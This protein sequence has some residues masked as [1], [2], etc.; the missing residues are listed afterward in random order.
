M[1][2][3]ERSSLLCKKTLSYQKSALLDDGDDDAEPFW[4]VTAAEAI[5]FA[6]T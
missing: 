4:D 6:A 3:A 1:L 2:A 5:P